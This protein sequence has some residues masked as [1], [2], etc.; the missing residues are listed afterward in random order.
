MRYMGGKARQAKHI[1]EVIA[2]MRGDRTRYVEPF[3][4][5]AWVSAAVAPD[6]PAAVLADASEPL[7]TLWHAVVVDGWE[8]PSAMTRDEYDRLRA[9]DGVS[10]LHG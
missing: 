3:M 8:P 1:R 2:R 4:G 9:E 7:V 6:F 5:G 10:A